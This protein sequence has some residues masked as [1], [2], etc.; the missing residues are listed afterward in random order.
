[1]GA[2]SN[3]RKMRVGDLALFYH[4]S[5]GKDTAI[6]G[7]VRVHKPSYPDPIDDRWCCVDVE[8]VNKFKVP[9]TLSNL[10]ALAKSPAG[11]AISDLGLF[12]Q[13]RLSVVPLSKQEW[14]FLST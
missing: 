7:I 12:R 3:L 13:P 4:S 5:A 1:M 9:I 2:R 6:V 10:K 14:Q 11:A 8:Y